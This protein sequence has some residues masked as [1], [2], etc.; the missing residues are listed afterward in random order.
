MNARRALLVVLALTVGACD[1]GGD[2]DAA[3]TTTTTST[4]TSTSTTST[5]STSTPTTA[6]PTTT[7]RAQGDSGRGLYFFRSPTNNIDCSISEEDARCDIRDY[8]FTPPP[9]PRNCDLD[10]GSAVG[11]G[12]QSAGFICHGDTVRDDGAAV[13]PYG[14]VVDRGDFRCTSAQEGMTCEHRPSRHRFFL[15]RARYELA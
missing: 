15:S 12:A 6:G 2:D 4:T 5:T 11:V 7:V 3:D 14:G 9:K 8:T 10:W 1:S 13:L